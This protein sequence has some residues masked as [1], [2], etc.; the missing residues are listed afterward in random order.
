MSINGKIFSDFFEKLEGQPVSVY[1]LVMMLYFLWQKQNALE[2]RMATYMQQ[3][4]D[5]MNQTINDNTRAMDRNS[6]V[7]GRNTLV[8]DRIERK[9]FTEK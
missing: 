8:I 4:R 5:K 1:I 7:I 3:D 6:S 9:M 2:D